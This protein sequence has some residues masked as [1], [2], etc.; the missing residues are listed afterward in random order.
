M[1]SKMTPET[2][3]HTEMKAEDS[4]KS[5]MVSAC[6]SR[7]EFLLVV[8]ARKMPGTEDPAGSLGC[9]RLRRLEEGGGR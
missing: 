8:G 7:L 6:S 5:V 2:P 3:N 4:K 1:D 9:S